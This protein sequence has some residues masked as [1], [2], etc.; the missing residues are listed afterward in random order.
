[1]I[2]LLL[3]A[4]AAFASDSEPE[5]EEE[6]IEEVV[7]TGTR[8]PRRLGEAPVAVEVITREAIERSGA[9]DV[10]E[11]LEQQRGVDVQR[12]VLGAGVRLR[13]LD[14]S[15]TLILVDGQRVVGSK[16]GTI[17]LSRFPVDSI[18]RI[19]IVKG[20]SSAL[21]GS[22]ALG[23]VVNIITRRSKSSTEAN[24]SARGGHPRSVDTTAGFG[25]RSKTAGLR[26]DVGWHGSPEYDRDPDDFTTDVNALKQLQMSAQGDWQPNPDLT[27]TA[28]GSWSG[29]D[30]QGTDN[31]LG[32][33]VL[34]RRNLTED[35]LGNLGLAWLVGEDSRLGTTVGLSLFR[36]QY[37]AD[38][39]RASDL[40]LYE[41]T[42]ERL[43]QL[44]TQ[45]DRV[46]GRQ[47]FTIGLEG[48][49]SQITS[50]RLDDGQ[51]SRTRGAVYAQDEIKLLIENPRWVIVPGLRGDVDSWFGGAMAPSLGTR[52]D[53][54]RSEEHNV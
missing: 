12:S 31:G 54:I 53:P 52:L 41:E 47:V 34:D 6:P 38:Q 22:D 33:A 27:L 50:P 44:T 25:A 20:A 26:A 51:G 46:W 29:Q 8:S 28:R 36:D 23:G 1:M 48:F 7:V 18:E 3:L 49:T 40:D 35:A 10:A 39:R 17:D 42:L 4:T 15:H 9:Q 13:G 2:L 30:A 5:E 43:A 45:Y 21:Y 14:A 16:D 24:L 19:E 32:G 11:V 37:V